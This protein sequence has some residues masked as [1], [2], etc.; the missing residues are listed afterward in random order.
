MLYKARPNSN[1]FHKVRMTFGNPVA[2]LKPNPAFKAIPSNHVQPADLTYD[3]A[4]VLT[5][6]QIA[7]INTAGKIVFHSVGDTGGINGTAIQDEIAVQM[8]QQITNAGPEDTPVFF[9]HLGDVVYYN[10]ETKDYKPQ[11]YE[12]Y[13]FYQAAI[14]AIPGNHDGDNSVYKG[15]PPDPEAQLTGFFDNFCAPARVPSPDSPYKYLM[16]QPWPYWTLKAPFVTIIGLYSNI[17]GSL[18]KT[19]AQQHIQHQYNWFVD[20]LKAADP[21]KCLLLAVHHPPFSLDTAHGGYQDILDAID[22]AVVDSG[23]SPDAVFTGHVHNYQ[24]YTRTINGK[25]YPYVIAGAGGYANTQKSMH[26]L[27]TDPNTPDGKIPFNF[28]TTRPDVILSSYNTTN[29]G[30]LRL[31]VDANNL[32]GEYFINQFDNS[33]VPTA[34]FDTFN[35][36]WRTGIMS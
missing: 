34:P 1:T 26:Q 5:P 32:K 6:A 9:Y 17:D 8:E 36:N 10:G 27:Q 21:D 31:T 23:R 29:P 16:D 15:D 28:Q 22:Q 25:Q 20:Q 33:P 4:R 24:R 35:L 14:F 12:P 3:V 11:F 18:D 2:A 13:Q 19:T 30:F 7:A